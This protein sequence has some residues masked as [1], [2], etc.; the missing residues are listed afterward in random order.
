MALGAEHAFLIAKDAMETIRRLTLRA[1]TGQ[2][3]THRIQ[4]MH[5]DFSVVL[6]R[7]DEIACAGH[8]CAHRPHPVQRALAVGTIP[9]PDVL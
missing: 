1:W 9:L 7:S 3:E 5:L 2:I 4:P 6:Q 8:F